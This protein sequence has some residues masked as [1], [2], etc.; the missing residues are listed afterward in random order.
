MTTS[1]DDPVS[2]A[3]CDL[4]DEFG[5]QA[6]V[7]G[8]DLVDFGGKPSFTGAAVTIKCFEDNGLIRR[9]VQSPG[10]GCVL[11]VD[12][13]ASDRCA[14]LGDRLAKEAVVNGWAGLVID[15]RVRD[16]IELKTLDI[17]IKARGTTPRKSS[18]SGQGQRD[19]EIWVAGIP[20][21]PGDTIFAD[22][23]GILVLDDPSSPARLR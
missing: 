11:V 14:L 9:A 10:A 6:R 18:K 2:F 5:D 21:R 4:Y 23:D 1:P 8:S 20:V 13:G 3:T 16:S 17:G 22:G 15:G 19:V 12:G 7:I